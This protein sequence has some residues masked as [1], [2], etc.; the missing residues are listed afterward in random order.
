MTVL[1]KRENYTVNAAPRSCG[2]AIELTVPG[3]CAGLRLDQALA[4]LLPDFSRTR[5]ALWA[6]NARVELDGQA[7]A[8]RQKVWGG[9]KIRV[10][11]EADP[12]ETA[13]HPQD[14]PLDVIHE[15]DALLVVN[16][17]AGLVVHP[18]NGHA[19]DTLVNAL[20][21][22]VPDLAGIGGV[23]RPGIVHRLDKDTSGLLLV[24]KN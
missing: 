1:K 22:H 14:I 23:Q 21:A 4:R 7:A 19:D 24:A 15:D 5:L 9:E 2:D 18:A 12:R 17:P 20:L 3:D 6:R 13:F 8:P 11:P 16:K 10:N